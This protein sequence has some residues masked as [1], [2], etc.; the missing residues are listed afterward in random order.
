MRYCFRIETA[1]VNFAYFLHPTE[2]GTDNMEFHPHNLH[3]MMTYL[4]AATKQKSCANF[5]A[6]HTDQT[7]MDR[8][9]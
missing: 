4:N 7:V 8:E 1:L 9:Q 3:N 6:H 2:E 5:K